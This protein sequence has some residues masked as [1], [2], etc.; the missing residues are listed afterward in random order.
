MRS[1]RHEQLSAAD[2]TAASDTEGKN[3]DVYGYCH[4]GAWG[5][6]HPHLRVLQQRLRRSLRLGAAASDTRRPDRQ[7]P[8]AV[9]Q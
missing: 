4:N 6:T 8:N 3:T 9:Y 7:H 2:G 1:R 5:T